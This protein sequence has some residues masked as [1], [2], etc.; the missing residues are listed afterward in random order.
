MAYIKELV[1]SNNE[2]LFEKTLDFL[3]QTG[4]VI[5]IGGVYFYSPV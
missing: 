4:E 5:E 3:Q 1:F 2:M